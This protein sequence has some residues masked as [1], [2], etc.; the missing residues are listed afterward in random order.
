MRQ[1]LSVCVLALAV[2][3]PVAASADE[4]SD[5][6]TGTDLDRVIAACTK[7]IDND[8]GYI[9]PSTAPKSLA[10]GSR[11]PQIGALQL[12][13]SRSGYA[14]GALDGVYG[15]ATQRAVS[16][17]RRDLRLSVQDLILHSIRQLSL[18]IAYYNRGSSTL[19]KGDEERAIPDFDQSIRLNPGFVDAYANRG[20]AYAD[21]GQLARAIADYDEAIRLDPDLADTYADRGV[22]RTAMGE[23]DKAMEDFDRAIRLD[24]QLGEAYV[25]RADAHLHS[26]DYDGAIA[27][28]NQAILLRPDLPEGYYNRAGGYAGKGD[29]VNATIDLRLVLQLFPEDTA[30][31]DRAL[32]R[33]AEIEKLQ[34]T[35]PPKPAQSES[36]AAPTV[37]TEGGII[38][39]VTPALANG[40]PITRISVEG[41]IRKGDEK[42]F[43]RALDAGEGDPPIIFLDSTG[44]DVETAL[45]IG[46]M[47]RD[48]QLVTGVVEHA[49]CVSACALVWLAGHTRFAEPGVSIG[50]HAPGKVG[51]GTVGEW[52]SLADGYLEQL[53]FK[54]GA[55]S[56]MTEMDAGETRWLG[57]LDAMRFGIYYEEWDYVLEPAGD[58]AG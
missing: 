51:S 4:F 54:S 15:S 17:A 36:G 27:D 10:I 31:R 43:D 52:T 28:S 1:G 25:N 29:L 55:I 34:V 57:P 44:G 58:V 12:F 47:I 49:T 23:T 22:A 56:Y 42:V 20:L 18:S 24:P 39:T 48:K 45:A 41:E 37:M 40:E 30:W 13:L 21:G 6:R 3:V 11:G 5:C 50:F 9:D 53:G 16:K 32:A 7:L 33:I 26:E 14:P 38:V 8:G 35:P 2:C 46:E 19:S